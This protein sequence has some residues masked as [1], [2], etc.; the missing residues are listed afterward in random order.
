MVLLR[1][2]GILAPIIKDVMMNFEEVRLFNSLD[3]KIGDIDA[4]F[5]NEGTMTIIFDKKEYFIRQAD[6]RGMKVL[7]LKRLN[8]AAL[9]MK[10]GIGGIVN[11]IVS[12]RKVAVCCPD[13]L[14]YY[15]YTNLHRHG[16]SISDI[17][18][19]IGINV[20]WISFHGVDKEAESFMKEAVYSFHYT[21]VFERRCESL[22]ESMKKDLR[23]MENADKCT[24]MLIN[25]GAQIQ[26]GELGAVSLH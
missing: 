15:F 24:E 14:V 26:V 23:I 18:E 17:K 22:F 3:M 20:P 25:A 2:D 7:V 1:T 19:F 5:Q 11:E 9:Q 6:A 16:K 4:V 13:D 8:Y 21:K 10:T 12:N